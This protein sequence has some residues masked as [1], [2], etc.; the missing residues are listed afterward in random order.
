LV[1]LITNVQGYVGDILGTKLNT[2]LSQRY[3][4]HLLDL[5][6]EFYDNEIT[7]RL[8]SRLERSIAG[9]SELVQAMANN[10][11]TFFLASAF[12]LVILARYSPLVALLLALLF[13]IY[14]G[15]TTVTSRSWQKKQ[16]GINA[17]TDFVNGRF[18]EAISNIR[19]VKSFVY[20]PAESKV[21]ARARRSIEAQTRVQSSTPAGARGLRSPRVR[22]FHH[23]FPT[24]SGHELAG[25]EH[26][27]LGVLEKG[28]PYPGRVGRRRQDRGP[29]MLGERRRGVGVPGRM[30]AGVR[31]TGVMS[32]TDATSAIMRR[33]G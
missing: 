29:E 16:A 31:G 28:R 6:L 32:C 3:Y 19:V 1:S 14:I 20:E 4:D 26:R 15:L 7:G 2:L 9:I 17:D 11:I 8:T 23:P 22:L 33:W 18:M 27:A 25:V 5:P 13:P 24:T 21:F 10:F 30:S 12:T